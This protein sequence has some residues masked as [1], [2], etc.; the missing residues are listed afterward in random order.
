M[1]KFFNKKKNDNKGFSL[2]ELIIVV[3]IM[4]ILVGLLAPQ[5]LKY[6]EKSRKSAD[7]SNLD[8]MVRAIQI[9]AADAEVTL[10]EDTYT[11]TIGKDK[12]EVKATSNKAENKK[13]AEDALAENA[14]D[15][16]KTKLKSNKWDNGKP[17]ETQKGNATSVSAVITVAQ[18]GG[19][20]VKYTPKSLADYI[21]KTAK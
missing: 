18:D 13:V 1:L 3:A 6:V 14:P 20:T 10:P 21:N 16:A 7:A 19:T 4:A 12:T 17:E 11:I 8:E 9:Y 15:W 5:Y 2:V